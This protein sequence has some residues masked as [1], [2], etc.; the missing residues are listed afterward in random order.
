MGLIHEKKIEVENL[1]TLP[2]NFC[3]DF[4]RNITLVGLGMDFGPTELQ[5]K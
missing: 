1:V 2:L 3:Q 5:D 4:F